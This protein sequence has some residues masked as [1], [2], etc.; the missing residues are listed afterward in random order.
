V[1]PAGIDVAAPG[2]VAAVFVTTQLQPESLKS[3]AETDENNTS[4]PARI[5]NIL[6]WAKAKNYNSIRSRLSLYCFRVFLLVGREIFCLM[7]VVCT[8]V[9][10][11]IGVF[12]IGFPIIVIFWT[13]LV[14]GKI[15]ILVFARTGAWGTAGAVGATFL[16]T[17]LK[18]C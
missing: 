14:L 13:F 15:V 1:H 17:N 16:G 6:I 10:K 18:A 5:A 2:A 7:V 9:G 11:D 3:V 12:F 8:G 4:I